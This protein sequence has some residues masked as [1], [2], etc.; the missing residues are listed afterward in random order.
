MLLWETVEERGALDS[1]FDALGLS[2]GQQQLFSLTRAMLH[3]R[4][5]V[6]LDQATSSV[7]RHTDEAIQKVIQEEFK[8]CT[9]LVVAHLL[10]TI[11]DADMMV[12]VD[13]GTIV[14]VG[15][16]KVLREEE[17]LFRGWREDR[18]D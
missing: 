2:Q 17:L 18:C 14:D 4:K 12:V 6:L 13:H 11:G 7:D 1:E 16:S 3:K 5:V 15:G 10:E 8:A 9:A